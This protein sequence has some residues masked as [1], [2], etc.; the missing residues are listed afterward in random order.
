[1]NTSFNYEEAKEILT[2]MQ[3]DLSEMQT[4]F[5]QL[6]QITDIAS[7]WGGSAATTTIQKVEEYKELFPKFVARTNQLISDLTTV[8]ES[9]EKLEQ[10]QANSAQGLM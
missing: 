8:I 7:V 2:S 10:A 3:S 9:H 6:T 5:N 1:M 4:I